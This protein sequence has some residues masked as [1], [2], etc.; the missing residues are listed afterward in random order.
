MRYAEPEELWPGTSEKELPQDCCVGNGGGGPGGIWKRRGSK[1]R[2][3]P[4]SR[5]VP[6]SPEPDA[7]ASSVHCTAVKVV[8][9]SAVLIPSETLTRRR[10]LVWYTFGFVYRRLARWHCGAHS[11]RLLANLSP[12]SIGLNRECLFFF[13]LGKYSKLQSLAMSVRVL[14]KRCLARHSSA[15]ACS[16]SARRSSIRKLA[17]L[18]DLCSAEDCCCDC[19]SNFKARLIQR[20]WFMYTVT[21][22]SLH[23]RRPKSSPLCL[24]SHWTIDTYSILFHV[25]IKSCDATRTQT[26]LQ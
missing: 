25:P 10:R 9:L 3:G 18:F 19:K 14:R 2:E 26:P 7:D 17:R 6:A 15:A 4:A 23:W 24:T 5:E 12:I 8:S 11:R 13:V 22:C 16:K 1:G 20:G 21:Q